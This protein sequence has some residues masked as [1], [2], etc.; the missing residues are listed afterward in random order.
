[1][2]PEPD[3]HRVVRRMRAAHIEACRA[4]HAQ[5]AGQQVWG[6]R[7]RTLGQQVILRRG[8]RAWLRLHSG[9]ADQIVD[10]F[11][12]GA[13]DAQRCL[14]PALPRPRLLGWHD[15]TGHAWAYRAELHEYVTTPLVAR[16]AVITSEPDL[17]PTWW[18]AARGALSDIA[19]VPTGRPSI[20]PG[21]L[22]WAMP[23]YLGEPIVEAGEVPWTTA[24]GDFHYANL[25]GPDLHILDWEGW[26]I[27]PAGYD[28]AMLHSYS[29]L[30]PE[31]AARI[32]D[33]FTDHLHTV[34]GRIAE[35]AVI[36]E[37][38]HTTTN[39]DNLELAQPLLR[40]AAHLLG[41]PVPVV[42]GRAA[43]TEGSS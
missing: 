11:W 39:G 9:P 23:H 2:W 28:A 5:P 30:V 33:E 15:R 17:P 22:T 36:T 27:A 3:D 1:M 29:L 21:F 40:R 4:F 34:A 26:G 25:C 42:Q 7:G 24:H 6:W 38:L 31:A 41:R 18:A 32:R 43:P 19:T 10:T 20:H 8:R 12:N 37:L 13:I 35:L 16:Q 14:P